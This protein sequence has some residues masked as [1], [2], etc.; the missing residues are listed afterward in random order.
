MKY[1]SIINQ[2]IFIILMQGKNNTIMCFS[3]HLQDLTLIHNFRFSSVKVE[4]RATPFGF[5][6]I[7]NNRRAL[8]HKTVRLTQP[9]LNGYDL[10]HQVRKKKKYLQ[11]M[12]I[13]FCSCWSHRFNSASFTSMARVKQK[14]E[15]TKY[16]IH[17]SQFTMVQRPLMLQ[18]QQYEWRILKYDMF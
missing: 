1:V 12:A 3:I 7:Y 17:Q 5:L 4:Y 10:I 15:P 6:C 16:E 13:Q 9:K 8:F 14:E 18:L 2:Y 11:K